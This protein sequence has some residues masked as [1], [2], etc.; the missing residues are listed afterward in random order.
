[1]I[2]L[3]VL[4]SKVKLLD[5]SKLLDKLIKC[6]HNI[7]HNSSALEDIHYNAIRQDEKQTP[8]LPVATSVANLFTLIKKIEP[9]N[10]LYFVSLDQFYAVVEE[11]IVRE[12]RG[13]GAQGL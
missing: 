1:M 2:L 3:R 10:P 13:K 8:Y 11:T 12:Y 9:L 7:Q 4:N 5:D 6:Q